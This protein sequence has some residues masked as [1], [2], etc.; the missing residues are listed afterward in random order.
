MLRPC[1]GREESKLQL[2]SPR[3]EP[4]LPCLE[5]DLQIVAGD[6]VPAEDQVVSQVHIHRR[7]RHC[8]AEHVTQAKMD[9]HRRPKAQLPQ[10]LRRAG[11]AGPRKAG[12][13][14]QPGTR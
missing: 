1:C 6:P 2:I 10:S 5:E 7:D 9:D 3:Q 11:P 12:A 14:P 4:H 8:F 13:A